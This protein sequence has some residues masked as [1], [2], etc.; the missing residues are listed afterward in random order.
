MISQLHRSIIQ[1]PASVVSSMI[2]YLKMW[3]SGHLRR[4]PIDII[5][6][7]YAFSMA[8]NGWNY[9]RALIAE[10][11]EDPKIS[12]EDSTF[13]RFFQ[14]ERVR[15]T[16][17]FNDL[18][19]LHN[20][21]TRLHKDGYN[22]YYDTCPWG[23]WLKTNNV[24]GG[25]PWGFHYDRIEGQATRDRYGYRNN[26]WYQPG[27]KYPLEIEWKH[28]LR[29]Y[30]KIKKGYYPILYNSFPEVTLLV[31]NDGE[32]R[33]VRTDGQHRLAILSHLGF[34]MVT[35]YIPSYARGI[36]HEA[37][38]DQWYYVKNGYCTIHQAIEIFNAFFILNGRE[39]LEYLGLPSIY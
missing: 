1:R 10:Y 32:M 18:L 21:D 39:R 14:D 9:F 35:V 29:L 4:L 31:R 25:R 36:V 8:P 7:E 38:V 17:Y 26:P 37:E 34:N 13:F 6:N 22:F 30:H 5:T 24:D 15:S 27:D 3:R 11:E 12:L 19:F 20:P 28:T 33:A 23:G 16:R 2:T